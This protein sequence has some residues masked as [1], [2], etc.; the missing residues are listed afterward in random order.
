MNIKYKDLFH[1]PFTNEKNEESYRSFFN[2]GLKNDLEANF[3]L[4]QKDIDDFDLFELIQEESDAA[5]DSKQDFLH[6]VY[7]NNLE[8]L[9]LLESLRFDIEWI[10]MYKFKKEKIKEYKEKEKENEAIKTVQICELSSDNLKVFLKS[11]DEETKDYQDM[12]AHKMFSLLKN[13]K[14]KT[15]FIKVENEIIA[16]ITV[17][18]KTNF[19]EIQN[20]EVEKKHRNQGLGRLLHNHILEDKD[21]VLICFKDSDAAEIYKTWGYEKISTHLSAIKSF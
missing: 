14:T 9:N 17:I 11:F 18:E 4:I 15:F 5:K 6:I 2:T 20:F 16:K 10:E 12:M 21:S 7:E 1:G 19:I 13:R 8:N 3:I